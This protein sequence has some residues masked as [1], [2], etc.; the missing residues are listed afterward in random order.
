[1]N[2]FLN[3]RVLTGVNIDYFEKIN[4]LN[5]SKEEILFIRESF[6]LIKLTDKNKKLEFINTWDDLV[7]EIDFNNLINNQI[8]IMEGLIIYL[9]C[10]KTKINIYE[11]EKNKK[12]LKIYNNFNHLGDYNSIHILDKKLF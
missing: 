6:F 3:H 10:L 1:M 11:I 4:N 5:Y 2:D 9:T 12:L 7:S 8:G